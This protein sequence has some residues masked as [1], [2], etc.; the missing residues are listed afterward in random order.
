M[1]NN[2]NN[3]KNLLSFQNDDTPLH[4]AVRK[5][6]SKIV[7]YLVEHS[8]IDITKFD[9]VKATHVIQKL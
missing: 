2:T 6:K 7:K 9:Q 4:C 8:K 3:D 1:V 5:S